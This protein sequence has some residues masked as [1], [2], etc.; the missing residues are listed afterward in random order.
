MPEARR[1]G[2]LPGTMLPR[3][4]ARLVAGALATLI[5]FAVPAVTLAAGTPTVPSEPDAVIL[6]GPA[7]LHAAVGD[8]DGDGVRE[9]VR[10]AG[11]PQT[12]GRVQ[13]EAW[14]Q[15]PDGWARA[16]EARVLR[17]GTSVEEAF[18]ERATARTGS[19][20]V[21]VGE[22]ARILA[23]SDGSR[24]RL[25]IAA[26]GDQP[27]GIPC[28]LSLWEPV[29]RDGELALIARNDPNG[30][31]ETLHAIDLDGDGTDELLMTQSQ[32]ASRTPGFVAPL[33]AEAMAWDGT[34]FRTLDRQ[35]FEQG[36][37]SP[38]WLIGDTDLRPGDEAGFLQPGQGPSVIYRLRLEN[39]RLVLDTARV[40]PLISLVGVPHD[41]SE[42]IAYAAGGASFVA[43]WK[44]DTLEVVASSSTSG[45]LLPA[46]GAPGEMRL[47]I[48]EFD[49]L[50]LFLLDETLEV[51]AAIEPSVAALR[52]TALGA[53]GAWIGT[54]PGGDPHGRPAIVFAGRLVGE[55]EVSDIASLVGAQ[56]VGLLGTG[57]WVGVLHSLGAP[58]DLE[59]SG[60]LLEPDALPHD[61]WLA[62]VP[63]NSLLTPETAEGRLLPSLDGVVVSMDRDEDAVEVLTTPDGF[64][65]T[66][67][68]PPGSR[69]VPV[70]LDP[71]LAG[72]ASGG[73][74]PDDGTF[75]LPV[76]SPTTDAADIR[77]AARALVLTPAGH[78][79]TARWDVQVLAG[80]PDLAA[81][82]DTA[83]LSFEVMLTG[84]TAPGVALTIDGTPVAVGADGSFSAAVTAPP[85]P[86]TVR[87][88]AVDPVGN[89]N[90]Q[91]VSVVGLFDYRTLPWLPIIAL[92][93]LLAGVALFLRAPRRLNDATGYDRVEAGALEEIEGEPEGDPPR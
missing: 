18:T 10:L 77:F 68:A 65:A 83:P 1:R 84:R 41:A 72:D 44:G 33:E 45:L 62:I 78:A 31:G 81:N 25:L 20:P 3:L 42:A 58:Y 91:L 32:P 88:E 23:W 89:R 37:G 82:P 36:G 63:T 53:G 64:V 13:V 93:T 54:L 5:S 60:G 2:I 51:R 11:G 9:L 73:V 35:T 85:W 61:P 19:T 67:I 38:I 7:T 21:Y 24:E 6:P 17:R 27:A 22:P 26:L 43:T 30:P 46:V 57:E 50:S 76:R 34:M 71:P 40:P 66:I 14:G 90:V 80:P 55:P 49:P 69:V 16:G 75:T 39:E 28:C 52:A 74:V 70:A 87:L 29:L 79:Y 4:V 12:D 92:L 8:L 56:P 48:V 47:P 15:G 59:R 86:Q